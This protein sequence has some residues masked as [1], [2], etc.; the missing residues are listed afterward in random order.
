M[1]QKN[2][3]P[4]LETQ[5]AIYKELESENELRVGQDVYIISTQ[6]L[7]QFKRDTGIL[8]K[9]GAQTSTCGPINNRN[10]I[11]KGQF[12]SNKREKFDYEIISKDMWEQLNLWYPGE[13][14]IKLQV[15]DS[16]SGPR[17]LLSTLKIKCFFKYD[18]PKEIITNKYVMVK[19]LRHQIMKLFDVPNDKETRLWDYWHKEFKNEL[20]DDC[21]LSKYN[22]YDGQE[23]YLDIKNEGK[24]FKDDSSNSSY[25]IVQATID[26]QK[27]NGQYN[28]S[29]PYFNNNNIT[30][31]PNQTNIVPEYNFNA[32][33]SPESNN[34]SPSI[35]NEKPIAPGVVGLQNI[36]NTCFFN[37]G[38]QCLLHNIPLMNMILGG[39]WDKDVKSNSL[40]LNRGELAKAFAELMRLVWTGDSRVITPNKLK[41]VVGQYEARFSNSEQQDCHE[42][43]T[44]LIN[45]LHEDLNRKFD[46]NL[47]VQTIIGNGENDEEIANQSWELFK[48]KNDSIM[49]DNFYGQFRSSL[50]CPNCNAVTTVFDPYNIISLPMSTHN[51]GLKVTFIPLNYTEPY[52]KMNL[53]IPAASTFDDVSRIVSDYIGRKVN[54]IIGG[55]RILDDIEWGVTDYSETSQP[56][57]CAFEVIP[58]DSYIFP[59]LIEMREKNENS[60]FNYSSN[61]IHFKKTLGKPFIIY[62]NTENP[63]EKEIADAAFA[64]LQCLWKPYSG[65][66]PSEYVKEIIRQGKYYAEPVSQF[67]TNSHVAAEIPRNYEG[68]EGFKFDTKFPKLEKTI[69]KVYLNPKFMNSNDGFNN[70][71][72]NMNNSNNYPLRN[73]IFSYYTLFCHLK[74][75][76]EKSIDYNSPQMTIEDCFSIFSQ[77][78]TLDEKNKWHCPNCNSNVCAN[79]KMDLWSAPDSLIINLKRFGASNSKLE[80]FVG[81]D[82]ILDLT[83]FI[84]GTQSSEE[85]QILYRLYGVTE[86]MGG[87]GSGHYTARVQVVEPH[88]TT[89][90]WYYFNDDNVTETDESTAVNRSAY[91]L[92]YQKIKPDEKADD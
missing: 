41:M 73:E 69:V 39:S 63:T 80:T 48:S 53:E 4:P 62:L 75:K 47:N 9:N 28:E 60:G 8:K 50:T 66:P 42:F 83:D 14:E 68:K 27:I 77:E 86:H 7:N 58:S 52:I 82:E 46:K 12:A 31:I 20:K 89:G 44:F 65:S 51:R 90:K 55:Y 45:G 21:E 23:V 72:S 29:V 30:N 74:P 54:V 22:I 57:L 59:C 26:S 43:L 36:G 11:S 40:H 56:H 15:V 35:S 16:R 78:E 61:V 92:F 10:L 85:Q 91:I 2:D 13:P 38:V 49:I 79:K 81:Y 17:V 88:H 6:W 1:N 64:Y 37:A 24:W 5:G 87:V 3:N 70:N 19:E 34:F 18:N 32:Y 67:F 76:K 71:M 84:V 33:N 25:D